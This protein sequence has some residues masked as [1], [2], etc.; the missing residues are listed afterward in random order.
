MT[1]QDA[2]S[3]LVAWCNS[4]V[5]YREGANN[6]NQY[7]DRLDKIE[8][9]TWGPKQNQPW[10]GEFV[11]AAFV[12]CFGVDAALELQCS[13]RPTSIPL[14]SAGAG[15]FKQAGRWNVNPQVGDVVFFLVNGAINH[16]GIVTSVGMGAITTVEGNSGDMVARR[17]YALGSPSIAGFGR[18]NWGLVA[19]Y[20]PQDEQSNDEQDAE[21]E[22]PSF[23]YHTHQYFVKI[24]LLKLGDYGPQVRNM[25]VML[26]AAGYKCPANGQYDDTTYGAVKSFQEDNG[27]ESDGEFGAKTFEALYNF[28]N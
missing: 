2:K 8:G 16:T 15:Y 23:L 19:N 14:C 12:E 26:D 27:L 10:C 25:Q 4:Q 9:L 21:P 13:S 20:D 1:I 22:K 24:N 5:G 28:S 7:A 17:T 18:P 11:L 6:W 3:R